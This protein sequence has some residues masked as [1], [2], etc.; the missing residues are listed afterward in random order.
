M[1]VTD[2]QPAAVPDWLNLDA[3]APPATREK[4]RSAAEAVEALLPALDAAREEAYKA[5][6]EYED[7]VSALKTPEDFVLLLDPMTGAGRLCEV[8]E[9]VEFLAGCGHRDPMRLRPY[10][11]WYGEGATL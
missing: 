3:L 10:P 6:V 1:A 8:L 9:R 2:Q 7:G 11:E 5:T 4:L